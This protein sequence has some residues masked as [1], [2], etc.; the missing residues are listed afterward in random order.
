MRPPKGRA[1]SSVRC[2]ATDAE[3]QVVIARLPHGRSAPI[4][5]HSVEIRVLYVLL[6]DPTGRPLHKSL[7]AVVCTAFKFDQ[8]GRLSLQGQSLRRR[9]PSKEC[10]M[11]S[12]SRDVDNPPIASS[13]G[14]V[15]IFLELPS[16]VFCSNDK[17]SSFRT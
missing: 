6:T 16:L 5:Q 9:W 11:T 1:S 3:A 15:R 12:H 2:V 17:M 4:T 14:H 13:R 10:S 8:E 7:D